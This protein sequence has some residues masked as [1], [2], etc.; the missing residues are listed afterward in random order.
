M[1]MQSILHI[2]GNFT[3]SAFLSNTS[4]THFI[5]LSSRTSFTKHNFLVP[6]RNCQVQEAIEHLNAVEF[7][8]Q[9]CSIGPNNSLKPQCKGYQ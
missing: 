9:T 2:Y 7:K 5:Q 8:G 4:L 6:L 1:K 3:Q